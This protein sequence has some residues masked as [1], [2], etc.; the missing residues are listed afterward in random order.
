MLTRSPYT[1]LQEELDKDPWKIFVCCIFC[2]LTRRRQAEPYFWKVLERW[3]SPKKLASADMTVLQD[4]IKPIGMSQKRSVALKR[5]SYEYTH[6]DWRKD[7]SV[8]YGIGKY[9]SDAY[10]IFVLDQWQDTEPKDGA[11][12]NYVNWRRKNEHICS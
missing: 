9:A 5:M 8:L 4:L 6:K 11:L 2:N 12:I 1:L 10:R 3:S 7:P